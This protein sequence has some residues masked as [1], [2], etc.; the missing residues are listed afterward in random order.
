VRWR[1]LG[2]GVQIMTPAYEG[3]PAGPKVVPP[4]GW[5]ATPATAPTGE[6]LVS[7]GGGP[8]AS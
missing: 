8:K 6:S 7:L 2:Y 4:D 5:Y 3:D 1:S